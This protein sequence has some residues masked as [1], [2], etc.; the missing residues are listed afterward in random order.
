MPVNWTGEPHAVVNLKLDF[1]A[2][3]TILT[4]AADIGQGSSTIL[5]QAVGEVLGL[6]AQAR[7]NFKTDPGEL[8]RDGT[9]DFRVVDVAVLR[10]VEVDGR[11]GVCR[12]G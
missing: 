6:R 1:D 2:G 11:R 7:R 4:G 10:T 9:A 12:R 8:L 3:I 5:A